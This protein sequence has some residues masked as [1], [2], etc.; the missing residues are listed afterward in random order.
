MKLLI[1]L[2]IASF[3]MFM[4]HAQQK[5]DSVAWEFT[6]DANFYIFP[7]EFIFL[8]VFQAN[9]EKLHLEARYN[10]ED[11]RTFS[12]WV[13]YNFTGGKKLE[14]VITPMLGGV[15]GNSNGI[16]PGLEFTL[17]KNRFELYSEAECL[18]ELNKENSF[19]YNW[20]DLTYSINDRLWA[21]ISAQRTRLYKTNLEIQ[22]GVL[23]GASWKK[24]E[25]TTYLYNVGFDTAFTLVTLTSNF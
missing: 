18:F 25:I 17:T 13:G 8:P 6:A 5:S 16:A 14:Y 23:V 24:F 9:K 12:G 11:L 22:R 10:Y 21:G 20:T 15:V 4:G 3:A 7:D 2:L 1:A 19:I